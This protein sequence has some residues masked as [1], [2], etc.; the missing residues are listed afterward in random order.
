MPGVFNTIDNFSKRLVHSILDR[1]EA[2]PGWLPIFG[3][4]AGY[5]TGLHF[6]RF[7]CKD[8]KTRII[9]TGTPDDILQLTDGSYHVTDYKTAHVT[10][11]QDELLPLYETQLNAYAYIAP[12]LVER[13]PLTPISGIS[14]TFFEPIADIADGCIGEHGPHMRFRIAWK[15]LQ[16]RCERLIPPLLSRARE[17]FELHQPPAHTHT[18]QDWELITCLLS[19]VRDQ[20]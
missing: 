13:D 8:L 20:L 12:R 2:W 19:L 17:I 3:G 7:Y 1:K 5:T 14:L 15:P 4:A 9:L 11:R 6:S 16:L 10:A 18:C